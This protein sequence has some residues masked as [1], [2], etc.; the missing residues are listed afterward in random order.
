MIY[1]IFI[2]SSLAFAESKTEVLLSSGTKLLCDEVSIKE[3]EINTHLTCKKGDEIFF[4]KG[5]EFSFTAYSLNANKDLK[6]EEVSEISFKNNKKFKTFYR[7]DATPMPATVSAKRIYASTIVSELES[8]NIDDANEEAKNIFRSIVDEAKSKKAKFQYIEDHVDNITIS[9]DN[10]NIECK[11]SGDI[12]DKDCVYYI[13]TANETK[14][15]K[16]LSFLVSTNGAI[17]FDKDKIID[18]NDYEIYTKVNKENYLINKKLNVDIN[19]DF[20]AQQYN[21]HSMIEKE[22]D[23]HLSNCKSKNF[24]KLINDFKQ[25][26]EKHRQD[27]YRRE[28]V[29]V[30]RE[31]NGIVS[32]SFIDKQL[33]NKDSCNNNF[34]AEKFKPSELTPMNFNEAMAIFED[35]KNMKDIAYK[36][37]PD[38]CAERAFIISERLKDRG[39]KTNKV[40][41]TG[42]LG[43]LNLLGSWGMHVAPYIEVKLAN[44]KIEKMIIDPAVSD[45]LIPLN[46]WIS[47]VKRDNSG[48][49]I[50]TFFPPPINAKAYGKMTI[51]FSNSDPYLHVENGLAPMTY[52]EKKRQAEHTNKAYLKKTKNNSVVIGVR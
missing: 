38:G 4:V 39:I 45:K 27:F 15:S 25:T 24:T 3:K 16:E 23:Y 34:K 20:S 52:D 36:H 44:N 8:I 1:F 9:F 49:T 12:A 48:G 41:L 21:F 10:T 13:C 32:T 37:M 50:E 22:V 42:N 40:W 14:G 11:K 43:P 18:K 47:L 6:Y 30:A 33:L 17:F 19:S 51:S 5:N 29:Q 26:R 46:D 2:L 28:L 7:I 31:A 35:V